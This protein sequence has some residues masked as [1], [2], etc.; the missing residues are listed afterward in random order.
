MNSNCNPEC[1][2]DILASFVVSHDD[3]TGLLAFENMRERINVLEPSMKFAALSKAFIFAYRLRS[4][5]MEEL[6]LEMNDLIPSLPPE[7]CL[8]LGIF[9][10]NKLEAEGRLKEAAK[11][12]VIGLKGI[13]RKHTV[14][15]IALADYMNH[16]YR[17]YLRLGY[18]RKA[19]KC[20]R[21]IIAIEGSDRKS[22]QKRYY[23][24]AISIY[25]DAPHEAKAL[26]E[27]VVLL[28]DG[29]TRGYALFQ[30]AVL[31]VR[32][33]ERLM[34]LEEALDQFELC[35]NK[36]WIEKCKAALHCYKG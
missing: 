17:L 8:S 13:A 5:K 36:V 2:I 7:Y 3:I 12:L 9:T 6:L 1:V 29:N 30:L 16:L 19:D 11:T 22:R 15:N 35:G 26:F 34:R 21:R 25:H 18:R 33:Y 14:S 27:K 10:S 23:N 4:I 28:R 24:T 20:A 31:E 32:R